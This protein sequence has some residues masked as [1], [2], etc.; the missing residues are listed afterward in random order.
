MSLS[1]AELRASSQGR[2]RRRAQP[3]AVVMYA[4]L[5]RMTGRDL[6]S[7]RRG[8]LSAARAEW[9]ELGPIGRAAF[10][11]VLLSLAVAVVLGMWL[12][13]L[14]R[15]HILGARAG[16]IATIA[17]EIAQRGLVPV[18][19]PTSS[20][21]QQLKEE[22]EVS[23][24]GGETVRVKL[25]T[26][27]GTVAYSDE[28]RLVGETFELSDTA[29]T[30]LEGAP[31]YEISD[32]S[33]PAHALERP[34][35]E[36]LEFFVPVH[37]AEGAIV[38]LFE[39]EQRTDAL[40]ATQS[41]VRRNVWLAIGSGIGLLGVFMASLTISSGRVLNRRR[42]QA[43]ELLGSLV[44]VQEDERRR[45]VG[46]L[47]DDVGQP[48]FRLLYGLEGSRSKLAPENPV[49]AELEGLAELTRDIDRTLRSELRLLHQGIDEDLS[50]EASVQQI[51][52]A[53][54]EETDLAIDLTLDGVDASSV[55]RGPKTALVQAVREAITNVRKH[56]KASH[57]DVTLHGNGR[58]LS[59]TVS[60][61]GNGVRSADGL[62][63]VTTRERLEAIGGS[64]ELV[65]TRGRGTVFSA[66]VP[67]VRLAK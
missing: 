25:W 36:L 18:G 63:I 38:G 61:D 39:V 26:V 65:S 17:D 47:H 5:G 56:A 28:P 51:I 44:R 48:L 13:R 32:L 7:D 4:T 46:A 50:L 55:A 42:R 29:R 66:S 3:T 64:L 62:G 41:D 27:D 11:G 59:V 20:T 35:G 67:L 34:L 10:A 24:L 40:N 49:S 22:I 8:I 31:A 12:P 43:E 9:T 30:A 53:T 6:Q 57:V 52:Q 54:R 15:S 16:L 2:S 21:Y 1:E 23:L 33:E 14:M 45:T 19:P 58:M 60:D 37:D